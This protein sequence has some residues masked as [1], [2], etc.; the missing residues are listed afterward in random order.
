MRLIDADA[1]LEVIT[2]QKPWMTVSCLIKAIS[3]A[4]TIQRED[5]NV[6]EMVNRFLSWKLP[7]D[8]SPDCGIAFNAYKYAN[9]KFEPIGT[10]LFTAQQAK[11]MIEYMLVAAP[12]DKE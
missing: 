5:V 2:E 4:P 10:N 3:N 1:L 9:H 7:S 11:A 8:F 12:T 6:D